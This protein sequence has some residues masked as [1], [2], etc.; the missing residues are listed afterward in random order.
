MKILRPVADSLA[1]RFALTSA[2]LASFALVLV[3]LSSWYLVDQQH[4]SALRALDQKEA[5]FNASTFSRTLNSVSL[6]LSEVSGSTLL[7]TALVDSSGRETYLVPF[8]NSIQQVSGVPIQILFTDFEG[9]VIAANSKTDFDDEQL[10]WLRNQLQEG[11][12]SSKI[13]TGTNGHE[14]VAIEPMG[15]ERTLT[16]E[17]ALFYKVALSDMQPLTSARLIWN[18]Q[19]GATPVGAKDIKLPVAAPPVFAPL[20]LHLIQQSRA[21]SAKSLAPQFISIFLI[22]LTLATAVFILGSR[23]AL[24]LTRDLRRLETFARTVVNRGFG[25]QRIHISGAKEVAGLARSINHMLDSLYQQHS[26]LQQE[27]HK[28]HQLANTIPQ[29]AWIANPDGW[30]HWYN[31]RWYEYT[32]TTFEQMQGWGWKNVLHP[33][34]LPGVIEKWQS[35]LATGQPFEATYGLRAG[36]GEFQTFFTRA[37]PLRDASGNILQW[38]GTATDVTPLEAAEHALRESQERL[39]EGMRAARMVV[40][41]W[42]HVSQKVKFSDNAQAV[43]GGSWDNAQAVWDRIDPDDL[44]R[45]HEARN[46]AIAGAGEYQQL[47]RFKRPDTGELIWLE[48]RGKLDADADGN[49]RSIRGV[50]LDVTERKR[51]EEELREADRRKDEFLAMLAHELRNPLAPI[52]AAAQLLKLVQ[53]NDEQVCSTSDIINRQVGHMTSLIDD[54]LDVSRVTRGLVSLENDILDLKRI[55]S[56]SIEQVQPLIDS[57]EHQLVVDLPATSAFVKGDHKR[58]VQVLANLLNNAAKYTPQGGKL[59]LSLQVAGDEAS[60]AV[61]DNGIGITPKMLPR[62][63]ELFSQAERTSDRSQGGLGL[64]LALVKSLVELHG[65]TVGAI[66]KGSGTGS[67]FTVRLPLASEATGEKTLAEA[68]MPMPATGMPLKLLVVDDNRDAAQMLALFLQ[69]AGHHVTVEYDPHAAIERARA[70]Q[71]QACLLD[72]GLPGMDGNQLARILRTMP[73]TAGTV[74]IAVTGYGQEYD[75]SSALAAGFDHYLV[76]P[77]D[78]AKLASMLSEINLLPGKAAVAIKGG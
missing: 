14:L 52:S 73:E 55:I 57:R 69:T 66:S 13:F 35:S 6:R 75:R 53:H 51:A 18:A 62:V 70:E 54:L 67:T 1:R 68:A 72:I 9:K 24:T 30:T 3:T 12:K 4:Q 17:G 32:G 41:D 27:T 5:E 64:G 21:E 31:D 45:L 15:Y 23:L 50:F 76:K 46:Q 77:V 36:D 34:H 48:V 74:L 28:F 8:L 16:P 11:K 19:Q 10:A 59:Q 2:A 56:D 63:F 26:L 22:A 40:W 38:F 65:G 49:I 33:D 7:A 43:L 78:T 29:L 39:K 60:V 25:T 61:S 47:V 58:L 20:G 71:P 44:A 37:A 42:N